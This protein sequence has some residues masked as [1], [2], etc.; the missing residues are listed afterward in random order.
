[1][2]TAR[3]RCG[4][5][6]ARENCDGRAAASSPP[7]PA[8]VGPDSY[9]MPRS[10]NSNFHGG[11]I[12]QPPFAPFLHPPAPTEPFMRPLFSCA[13]A[14]VTLSLAPSLATAQGVERFPLE[15]RDVAVYNLV[16]TMKV[17]GGAGDRVVVEV[18]RIGADAAQLKIETG[19]LRGRNSLRIHYP[20]DR[21]VYA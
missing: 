7:A 11:A 13:D 17:E 3:A 16:G 5:G 18:T 10:L 9:T 6:T 21:I 20:A 4:G 14:V 19:E 12:V 15:G 8:S 1:M 2:M